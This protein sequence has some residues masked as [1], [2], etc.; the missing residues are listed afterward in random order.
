[1][2]WCSGFEH[3]LIFVFCHHSEVLGST[4]VLVNFFFLSEIKFIAASYVHSVIS[5]RFMIHIGLKYTHE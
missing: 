5:Y 2:I 4:P 3:E 1:M